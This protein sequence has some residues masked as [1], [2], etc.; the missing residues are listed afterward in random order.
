MRVVAGRAKE[1]RYSV[2]LTTGGEL[3]DENG[4]GLEPPPEWSP[5][6]LLLAALVRCSVKALRYHAE[7]RGLDI[8]SASGKGRTVVTKRETDDRYALVDTEVELA[9]EVAPEPESD[10]LA[11]LLALAER[12]CFIGSSLTA[13]PSYCWVVN[14]RTIG[15]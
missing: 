13:K 14:G 2:D 1:L 6:H 4:V 7:R 3:T 12:D 8:R 5:E 10:A 9:V 15:S 11:E